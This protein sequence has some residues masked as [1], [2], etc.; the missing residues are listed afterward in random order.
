MREKSFEEG[1]KSMLVT[2]GL[3]TWQL[4]KR[5]CRGYGRR[6]RETPEYFE[7]E[8]DDDDDDDDTTMMMMMTT[9]TT[10]ATMRSQLWL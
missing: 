4:R 2:M 3:T 1:L 7:E 8:E 10:T 6:T 9:A 5:E